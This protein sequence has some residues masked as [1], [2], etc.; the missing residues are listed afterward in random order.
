MNNL[1]MYAFNSG[2]PRLQMFKL[3]N[4][5]NKPEK[6][7]TEQ[8]G[9]YKYPIPSQNKFMKHKITSSVESDVQKDAPQSAL[10]QHHPNLQI[11]KEEEKVSSSVNE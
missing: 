6:R 1:D 5:G 2:I 4:K 7:N 11:I 8:I 10:I 3:I 9:N